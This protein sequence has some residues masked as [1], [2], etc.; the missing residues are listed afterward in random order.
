MLLN[1][2]RRILIIKLLSLVAGTVL[3]GRYG[4]ET[5]T[6]LDSSL[7]SPSTV[8][9]LDLSPSMNIG[10]MP[11]GVSRL[12]YAK[13][14][15]DEYSKT[16][17][18][19][20]GLIAFN[21]TA[22]LL[23]PPTKDYKIFSQ[24]LSLLHTRSLQDIAGQWK[25]ED[26]YYQALAY[27]LAKKDST[28]SFILISDFNSSESSNYV[29]SYLSTLHNWSPF[30]IIA[31]WWSDATQMIDANWKTLPQQAVGRN[32]SIGKAFANVFGSEYHINP[33]QLPPPLTKSLTT[34]DQNT[35]LLRVA[36][37]LLLLWL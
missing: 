28:T 19:P 12:D 11:W 24:K 13:D 37:L 8:I 4:R 35:R 15:V 20:L 10:D 26:K 16:S 32:D 34:K 30:S 18:S 17:S 22:E 3:L 33:E 23:I 9:I 29:A 27:A 14:I 1:S 6:S 5:N 7:A 2:Y 31:L 21:E 36:A 25:D